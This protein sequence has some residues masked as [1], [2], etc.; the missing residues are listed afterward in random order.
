M[1]QDV[2]DIGEL[3]AQRWFQIAH[4]VAVILTL[5]LPWAIMDDHSDPASAFVLV[6]RLGAEMGH[7]AESIG[8][9]LTLIV[10]MIV[11]SAIHLYIKLG[12]GRGL[13]AAWV[14]AIA[15]LLLLP[16]SNDAVTVRW[17]YFATLLLSAPEPFIW[18]VSKARSA[19]LGASWAK[20]KDATRRGSRQP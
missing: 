4:G 9:A 7:N 18:C 3:L 17:G 2:F 15:P 13:W 1:N 6:F 20:L 12:G 14:I 5:A 19:Q 11:A 16:L 10:V 8:I